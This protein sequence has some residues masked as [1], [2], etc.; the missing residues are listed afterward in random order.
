LHDRL[1][2]PRA[3]PRPPTPAGAGTALVLVAVLA[4]GGLPGCGSGTAGSGGSGACGPIRREALD[5]AFLVHVLEDG[6]DLQYR[7]DPPTSGPHQPAPPVDGASQEP[8]TR[9]VQVGLL[10]QGDVLIQHR[11]DL[12]AEEVDTLAGLAG[13]GVVVAPNPDL[14]DAVVAT[15]WVHKRACRSADLPALQEFIDQRRNQGPSH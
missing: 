4:A 2:W 7:S 14:P 15:A 3:R 9:P 6:P 1:R 12:P 13:E 10:E 11:P 5:P 8:L